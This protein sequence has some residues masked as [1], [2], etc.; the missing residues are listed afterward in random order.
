MTESKK[1]TCDS[2]GFIDDPKAEAADR[3]GEYWIT[4]P[5]TL[6]QISL[7]QMGGTSSM[8]EFQ[9]S[10]DYRDDT[11]KE[12]KLEGAVVSWRDKQINSCR[13]IVRVTKDVIE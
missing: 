3:G 12:Y 4:R 6:E 7:S 1:R 9:S 5:C 10:T 11:G 2:E 8:S 13:P